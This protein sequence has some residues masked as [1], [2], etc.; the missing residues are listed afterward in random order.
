[1]LEK[2]LWHSHVT[3]N[4]FSVL[5]WN[6]INIPLMR[7]GACR[8]AARF[9]VRR[10]PA[11]GSR[12]YPC[13]RK[14]TL[15]RCGAAAPLLRV[16]LPFR[17]SISASSF[18]CSLVS[19]F[20]YLVTVARAR[21]SLFRQLDQRHWFFFRASAVGSHPTKPSLAPVF[22]QPALFHGSLI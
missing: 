2:I 3:N 21:G 8:A 19:R 10:L 7:F 4:G 20:V 16:P 13:A 15:S 5:C 12:S 1:M 9:L 18:H 6:R 22:V 11:C 14:I 17:M